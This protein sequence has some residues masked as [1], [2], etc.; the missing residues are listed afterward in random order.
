VPD[1]ARDGNRAGNIFWH[2]ANSPIPDV[3]GMQHWFEIDLGAD[4]YLDRLQILP[5]NLFQDTVKNFKLEVYNTSGSTV[6][7]QL[8]L[9]DKTTGD[10]AWGTTAIRNVVGSRVR[11]IRDPPHAQWDRAM[12]FG[13]TSP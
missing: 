9:P 4:F 7:S 8:F 11:I 3:Y 6:F 10:R 12:T 13:K 2:S 5:R 1:R